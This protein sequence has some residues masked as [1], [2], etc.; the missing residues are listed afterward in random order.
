MSNPAYS[1]FIFKLNAFN[2][3]TIEWHNVAMQ[4]MNPEIGGGNTHDPPDIFKAENISSYEELIQSSFYVPYIEHKE[5]LSPSIKVELINSRGEII[6]TD[7]VENFRPNG[8]DYYIPINLKSI[9]GS[10]E[11]QK[12][13]NNLYILRV[14]YHGITHKDEEYYFEDS[15]SFKVNIT[16]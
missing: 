15:I 16:T 11:N 2:S 14:R 6:A 3:N 9:P 10:P 13:S 8:N 7:Y 4:R 5:D 1:N 12:S